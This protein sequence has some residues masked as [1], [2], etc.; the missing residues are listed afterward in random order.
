MRIAA[1]LFNHMVP[2]KR[3]SE[4]RNWFCAVFG[5][6]DWAGQRVWAGA[7]S[8][9]E[10]SRGQAASAAPGNEIPDGTRPGG[11]AATRLTVLPA[12]FQDAALT[13][14]IPGAATTQAVL[15]P[16]NF[17]R[18][19]GTAQAASKTRSFNSTENSGEPRN[20]A[21]QAH[22]QAHP[23]RQFWLVF[24]NEEEDDDE[25]E[26]EH[27]SIPCEFSDRRLRRRRPINRQLPSACIN[28]RRGCQT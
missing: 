17:R 21:F 16:A 9:Q 7:E 5:G 23:H 1:S 11:A 26:D 4:N 14:A 18:P 8:A 22:P 3:Q 12:S 24:E 13:A 28:Q 25:P 27:D 2:V 10:I 15:P 19:A 20:W 6:I